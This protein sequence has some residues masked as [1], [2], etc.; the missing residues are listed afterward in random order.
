MAGLRSVRRYY[1]TL[2]L[3]ILALGALIYVAVDQFDI[4]WQS[5]RELILLTLL[6]AA[7][8]ILAAA[9]FAGLWLGLRK[10]LQR[11]F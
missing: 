7:V 11:F 6:T 8:V 3:S 9:F 5:M 1:R 4:P 2:V 10:L